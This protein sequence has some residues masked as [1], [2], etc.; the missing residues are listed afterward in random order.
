VKMI[1]VISLL[2]VTS[3]SAMAF[4]Q[5]ASQITLNIEAKNRTLTVSA[6]ARVTVDPELAILHLGF[7]TPFSDAQSA[8][9]SGAKISQQI[10][11]ALK[12]AGIEEKSI[13]SE[14]QHLQ[15]E[16][17]KAHKF[18]LVQS[19]TVRTPPGRA[20]EILDVAVGA[21]AT[22]SGEIDWIVLDENALENQALTKAAGKAREKAEVLASGMGVHLGN[23]I[24]LSNDVSVPQNWRNG[25]SATANFAGFLDSRERSSSSATLAIEPRKV[26]RIANVYAVFSIE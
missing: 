4:A 15:P 2:A 7:E 25:N 10:V 12:K 6:E 16:G 26:A 1:P 11:A 24:Y 18:K 19:W 21:G 9:A 13:R 17:A 23:L 5:Q 22:D 14:S 20:A 3:L 8:Y